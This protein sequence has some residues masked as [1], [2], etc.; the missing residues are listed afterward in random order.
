MTEPVAILMPGLAALTFVLLVAWWA[1]I[2]GIMQIVVAIELRKAI[3]GEWLLVLGGLVSI[4][5][6]GLLF[7]RPGAGLL[8]IVWIFGA[9]ALFYGFLLLFA[10][11]RLKALRPAV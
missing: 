9:Y 1:V 6:G 2:T 4:A 11:F 8:T 5:F 10:G 7:W 3:S